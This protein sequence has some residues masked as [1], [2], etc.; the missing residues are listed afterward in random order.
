MRTERR[1]P[2]MTTIPANSDELNCA[3]PTRNARK[4]LKRTLLLWFLATSLLPLTLVSAISYFRAKESLRFAAFESLSA[5]AEGKAAFIDNWFAYRFIDLESQA[6]STNNTRFLSELSDAFEASGKN[7]EEFVKSYTWSKI[8]YDYDTDLKSFRKMYNYYDIFLIDVKG[9]ILY[10]VA[11]EEDFGTNLLNGPFSGSHFAT[12]CRKTLANGQPTFSDL[13]Y[14]APSGDVPSGFIVSVVL[15]EEGEKLGAFAIQFDVH[16]ITN[17]ME[18]RGAQDRRS[19]A[20]L[21][22]LS[23]DHRVVLR[24]PLATGNASSSE[25]NNQKRRATDVSGL[26]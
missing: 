19:T 8:A 7:L 1:V 17:E 11:G 16:A 15:D 18:R 2:E 20:Y 21:V 24:T 6:T 22:G 12:A 23:G 9:N 10:S 26:S 3:V 4:S 5:E 25:S 13:D 14:Y